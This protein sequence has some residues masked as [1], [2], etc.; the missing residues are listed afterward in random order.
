MA[1]V[2]VQW[3]VYNTLAVPGQ[4]VMIVKIWEELII[5][6]NAFWFSCGLYILLKSWCYMGV[7]MP[8]YGTGKKRY[9]L[10][11]YVHR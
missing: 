7:R 2:S 11:A 9:R 10:R 4:V 1:S 6:M 3:Y 5:V 8:V